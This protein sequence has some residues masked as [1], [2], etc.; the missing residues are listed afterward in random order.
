M[1]GLV[2]TETALFKYCRRWRGSFQHFS[3]EPPQHF[4]FKASQNINALFQKKKKKK[5][6]KTKKPKKKKKKKKK[7]KNQK[8]N[9]KKRMLFN[10][11][12]VGTHKVGIKKLDSYSETNL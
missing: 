3:Y 2:T 5:K 4:W 10:V 12:W 8:K 7:K 6:K 11:L 9:K 1:F